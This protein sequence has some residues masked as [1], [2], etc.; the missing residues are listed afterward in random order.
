MVVRLNSSRF[1]V[2]NSKCGVG[3]VEKVGKVE[4]VKWLIILP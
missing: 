1:Q 3:M 4:K 2:P